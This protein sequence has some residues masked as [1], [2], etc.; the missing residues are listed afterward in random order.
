MV[1]CHYEHATSAPGGLQTTAGDLGRFLAAGMAGPNGGLPGR[2]VISPRFVALAFEPYPFTD[3]EALIGL[4]YNLDTSTGTLVARKSGDHRGFKPIVFTIPDLGAA[5]VTL[6]NSDRAAAGVFADI[7]CPWSKL[8]EG[9]PLSTICGRLHLIRNAHWGLAAVL[10]AI[11][12]WVGAEPVMGWIRRARAPIKSLR[13]WRGLVA[14]LLSFVLIAWWGFWYTDLP[15]RLLGYPPTFY[16]VRFD[17]WPTAF[18]WVSW[19]VTFVIIAI[20]LRVVVPQCRT[21]P[22]A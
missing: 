9:D 14:L 20:M 13:S 11:G 12:V 17:P 6:T 7:A 16:T 4:G 21:E 8:L 10:V 15:P 5:L 2:G 19:A 3:D 22:A 18:V 1:G